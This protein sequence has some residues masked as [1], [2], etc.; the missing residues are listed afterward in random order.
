MIRQ[1]GLS[2]ARLGPRQPPVPRAAEA[3]ASLMGWGGSGCGPPQ[4][5]NYIYIYICICMYK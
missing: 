2:R 3:N 5:N 4:C 1:S